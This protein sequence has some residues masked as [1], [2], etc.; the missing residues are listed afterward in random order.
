MTTEE[1]SHIIVR[2]DEIDRANDHTID[3]KLRGSFQ[4]FFCRGRIGAGAK[5]KVISN[6]AGVGG[7]YVEYLHRK[8]FLVLAVSIKMNNGEY[9]GKRT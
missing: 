6:R 4:C 3:L 8:C 2:Q 7:D 5:I 9:K 1:T